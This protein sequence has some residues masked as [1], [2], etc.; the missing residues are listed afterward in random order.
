MKIR[1]LK[2]AEDV[3]KFL[4]SSK[5]D[6]VKVGLTDIDGILRG[7]YM[8]VD[9]FIKSSK[10]GFGF[11]DVIFGWDSSDELY[12]LKNESEDDLYTGWHSGFPDAK[13]NIIPESGRINPFE[14]NVPFFLAELSEDEVC[15]RGLLNKLIKKME[16]VGIRSKSAFEYEFFLF[17]E[18]PHS[19]RSKNYSNR[20]DK[21]DD[22]NY[23]D[24]EW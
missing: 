22:W 6:Y 16:D 1:K 18:T 12:E 9:K 17:N 4:D 15:P 5:T 8:H 21:K 11:C 10:K 23:D 14:E 20:Q 19:I 3:K 13:A 2:S 24:N 7:K